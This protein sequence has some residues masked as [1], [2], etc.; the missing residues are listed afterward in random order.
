M[1]FFEPGGFVKNHEN[2]VELE[3]AGIDA[4]PVIHDYTG[5]KFDEI[6]YYLNNRYDLIALGYEANKRKKLAQ[7][8]KHITSKGCKVHV[9]GITSFNTL[10]D[11]PVH[12]CDSSNWTQAVGYGY[13]YYWNDADT[14]RNPLK[15]DM[16]D[17]IRFNDSDDQAIKPSYY[18]HNYP[19]KNDLDRYL[20]ENFGFTWVDLY[21]EKKHLCRE[22]INIHYHTILQDKLREYHQ[23]NNVFGTYRAAVDFKKSVLSANFQD[24]N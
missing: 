12:F 10:K 18:H 20:K 14:T 24:S 11:L 15:D 2:L 7:A 22:I 13:I 5:Q 17:T 19:F 3:K 16:T 9:L 4:L 23:R 8:V 21:G 6:G 1:R